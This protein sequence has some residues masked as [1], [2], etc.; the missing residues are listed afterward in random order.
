MGQGGIKLNYLEEKS[1]ETGNKNKSLKM[2]P[3]QKI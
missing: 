2:L 3:C 1:G